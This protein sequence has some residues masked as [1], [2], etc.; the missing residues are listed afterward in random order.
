MRT[1]G[2]VFKNALAF[3]LVLAM[4]GSML[5]SAEPEGEGT[6]AGESPPA[7]SETAGPAGADSFTQVAENEALRLLMDPESFVFAVENK[8]SGG[9]W[10]TNPPAREEDPI[11]K[12]KMRQ[13]MSSMLLV[14]YLNARGNT[15]V[16]A[17][18]T[19]SVSKGGAVSASIADGV[20]ITYTFES[21]G[22]TIPVELVLEEE[23]LA[24]RILAS[25]IRE[26]GENRVMKVELLPYFGA[27]G[28]EDDGYLFV[29]DG[30]GALIRFNNG[31]SM[32]TQY[33]EKV[34][35]RD[36]NFDLN[37]SFTK[38]E[39]IRL[40]VFGIRKNDEALLGIITK[41][42]AA[43]GVNASVGGK[44]CSYN[45]V[46]AEFELLSTDTYILGETVGSR[47]TL[48]NLYQEG[49]CTYDTLEVRY[50]FLSGESAGYD[51]MAVRYRRYLLEEGGLRKSEA[52]QPSLFLETLGAVRKKKSILGIPVTVNQ[53]LTTYAEA[54]EMLRTLEAEG[55][56]S[57]SLKYNGWDAS[58]VE[59]KPASKLSVLSQLGG[60]KDF[61]S[62]LE[63]CGGRGIGFYP[64]EELL[65]LRQ[66]GNGYSS[67]FNSAKTVSG[68]PAVTYRYN[69]ATRFKDEDGKT[70]LLE[71]SCLE[72]LTG[73]LIK[74]A[75][76]LG[77][78][79]LSLGA[80]AQVLYSDFADDGWNR[81]KSAD[82]LSAA[83]A[84]L[85]E[86][87]LHVLAAGGNAYLL[88]YTDALVD[89][90]ASGSRFDVEDESVPFMQ[91]VLRG[92]LPFAGTP[93][94]LSGDPRGAFLRAVETGASLHAYLLEDSRL[95]EL[96][97][98]DDTALFSAGFSDWSAQT[99]AWAKELEKA[100]EPVRGE[101]IRAH[102][103]VEAGLTITTYESGVQV[104]VNHTREAAE[105][106]GILVEEFGYAVV[107]EGIVLVR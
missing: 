87:G 81:Q 63:Y 42:A 88:P 68:N 90:P 22:F 11:A 21:E 38:K 102:E 15:D 26:T 14:T 52:V 28:P 97:N 80:A 55:V 13:Q 95:E 84:A 85:R 82:A 24:C 86:S 48:I 43:A 106:A 73:K 12:A 36:V 105:I 49:G 54:L 66:F 69:M 70:R 93:F 98:T 45:A 94:N 92:I 62:L 25:E 4:S 17:S 16:S 19:A 74:S 76:K 10:Y 1:K 40:P 78:P 58:S 27:G 6:T 60:K 39:D 8:A 9:R 99:A 77:L 33:S 79:G 37:R 67:F 7:V 20:R 34:F 103:R 2:P 75:G 89:V 5:L 53:E 72:K 35:G 57:L 46:R 91:I 96:Q 83:A 71:V 101:C 47:V 31:K 44:G 107:K 64:D 51:G 29:P 32:Y 104:L 50:H 30:S 100:L 65:L 59:G 41:G 61:Q 56:T 23:G 3:C 18:F